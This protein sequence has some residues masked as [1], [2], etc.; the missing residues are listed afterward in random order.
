MSE[1]LQSIGGWFAGFQVRVFTSP[2]LASLI[3]SVTV[4]AIMLGVT[5]YQTREHNAKAV[6][7]GEPKR[8]YSQA[9][10][11]SIGTSVLVFA[12]VYVFASFRLG[13]VNRRCRGKKGAQL[14]ECLETQR[15]R[16]G[17]NAQRTALLGAV[18]R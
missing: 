2:L 12:F 6:H 11:V 15:Y 17:A 14:F 10:F 16:A 4:L 5:I 13:A 3:S 1:M 9:V 8:E 7:S 18:Y